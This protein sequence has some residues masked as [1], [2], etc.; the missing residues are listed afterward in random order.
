MDKRLMD[1]WMDK[2]DER[3][4]THTTWMGKTLCLYTT[5]CLFIQI[6]IST[7]VFDMHLPF[8]L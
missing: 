8:R 5:I 7:N 4:Q 2:T 6:P 3:T 1:K